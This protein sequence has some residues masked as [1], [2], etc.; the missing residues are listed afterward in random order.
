MVVEQLQI[1]GGFVIEP[2]LFREKK[3]GVRAQRAADE[4]HSLRHELRGLGFGS[5]AEWE[6]GVKQRQA[7][8]DTPGAKHRAA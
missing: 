6:H 7:D 8:G 3:R 5:K 2:G 1:T 4:N